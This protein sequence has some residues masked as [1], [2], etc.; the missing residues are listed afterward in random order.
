MKSQE[1]Q[2]TIERITTKVKKRGVPINV[3]TGGNVEAAEWVGK[4]LEELLE[5]D[6]PLG[7][8]ELHDY[9]ACPKCGG[10]IGQSAYWCKHCGAYLR[11]K[12]ERN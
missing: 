6:E 11:Y 1:K 2:E 5:I 4:L 8:V 3:R 7:T 10:G 12:P 9:T